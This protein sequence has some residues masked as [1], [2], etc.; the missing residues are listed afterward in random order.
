[1]RAAAADI[2]EI[3]SAPPEERL[4]VLGEAM[5]V[6][7]AF[8]DGSWAVIEVQKNP[9]SKVPPHSHPWGEIYHILAGGMRIM[10]DGCV[11]DAPAGTCIHIPPDVVHQPLGPV[12]PNTRFLNIVGSLSAVELYRDL[13]RNVSPDRPDREK[14]IAILTRHG[15]TLAMP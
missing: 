8:P 9:D 12:Q 5:T 2:H 3:V 1:M 15:V 7:S 14:V 10:L 13:S 11:H 4:N 6:K